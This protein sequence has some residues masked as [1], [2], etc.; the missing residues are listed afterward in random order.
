M[1][2]AKTT[3]FIIS[4]TLATVANAEDLWV[5][6]KGGIWEPNET[7]LIAMKSGIE[8]YVKKEAKIRNQQLFSWGEYVFQYIGFKE[9]DKKYILVNGICDIKDRDRLEEFMLI[10]D[11]GSCHLSFKFNPENKQYYDLFINGPG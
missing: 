9:K 5:K 6:A 1:K 10:N 2:I 4:F 7:T 8:K 11:G 3:I